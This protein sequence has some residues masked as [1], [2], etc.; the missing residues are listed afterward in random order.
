MKR[1]FFI[2]KSEIS[3]QCLVES[4]ISS[5]SWDWTCNVKAVL[6]ISKRLKHFVQN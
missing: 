1:D 2:R 3:F 4:W 6:Q 5:W